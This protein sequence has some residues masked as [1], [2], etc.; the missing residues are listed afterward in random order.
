MVTPPEHLIPLMELAGVIS[1]L[2]YRFVCWYCISDRLFFLL[3]SAK[4]IFP[5]EKLKFWGYAT[6]CNEM[7]KCLSDKVRKLQNR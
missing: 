7:L 3:A 5:K 6:R 2:F 4:I 1:V